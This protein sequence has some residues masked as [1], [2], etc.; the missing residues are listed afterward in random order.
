MFGI[1]DPEPIKVTPEDVVSGFKPV[2]YNIAEGQ[3][4]VSF[5]CAVGAAQVSGS[6][7]AARRSDGWYVLANPDLD[8]ILFGFQVA[9]IGTEVETF[10][11]EME[12]ASCVH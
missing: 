9:E 10:V 8:L 12:H 1:H 11:E 7:R 3:A 2:A 5:T 6:M 4:E